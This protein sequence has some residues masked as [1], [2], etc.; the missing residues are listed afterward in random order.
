MPTP[1]EDSPV[2][3]AMRTHRVQETFERAVVWYAPG[4]W[5]RGDSFEMRAKK[6]VVV[7]M[8]GMSSEHEVSLKS[9]AMVATHLDT[10]VYKVSS[11]EI[12]REG[13]WRF[14]ESDEE[15]V[16]VCDAVPRL[17]ALH[18]DCVFIALHGP[19][20]E[21]GR[22]QGMFDVLGMPYVGSGCAASA[23]AIDKIRSKILVQTAGI[24]VAPQLEFTQAQWDDDHDGIVEKIAD[25]LGFPCVVKHPL[26]GSSLGMGIP[27]NLGELAPAIDNVFTYGYRIM[28]EE[29]L[30]GRE[31]TCGVLDVDEPEDAIALPITEIRPL[32]SQFFDYHA[33]YTP[34]ASEETTPAEI[35]DF[36]VSRVQEIALRAHEVVGC[37]GF[38]RSDMIL[39]GDEP[40]WLEINTIPGLTET[41]LYPQA[42]AA[43]GMSLKELYGKLVEAALI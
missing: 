38:S 30:P 31:L 7:L 35:D 14:P 43:A 32:K 12:T 33:K 42:A 17:K 24:R 23:L 16:E 11:V 10:D 3:G 28:A 26:Q 1:V 41:S 20:G 6:H 19:Y 22:I 2:L 40:V 18:P 15:Y 9:G 34:G 37:R 4:L 21:D 39:D 8:G 5:F 36:L 29:Y 13:E 25:V 27:Q